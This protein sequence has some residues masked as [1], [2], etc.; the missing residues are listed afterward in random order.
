M[1]SLLLVSAFLLLQP[2]TAFE[3]INFVDSNGSTVDAFMHSYSKKDK[4]K[5]KDSKE[6]KWAEEPQPI[7]IVLVEE[8]NEYANQCCCCDEKAVEAAYATLYALNS[9]ITGTIGLNDPIPFPN[10]DPVKKGINSSAGSTGKISV[11]EEGVYVLRWSVFPYNPN[12]TTTTTPVSYGIKLAL[13]GTPV[14]NVFEEI[15]LDSD[16]T[17]E[18]SGEYILRLEKHD[19]VQLFNVGANITTTF[20][21]SSAAQFAFFTIVKLDS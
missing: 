16:T 5:K 2:L 9:D 10:V 6:K 7:E 18:I 1:R 14:A 11:D 8:N 15:R 12:P 20:G 4:K 17:G 3:N 21:T 19:F 13:N